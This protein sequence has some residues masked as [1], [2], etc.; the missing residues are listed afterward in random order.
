MLFWKFGWT[1]EIFVENLS[2][3]LQ[4][5]EIFIRWF[6]E[7]VDEFSNQYIFVDFVFQIN[8]VNE[9]NIFL[10][11]NESTNKYFQQK[12]FLDPINPVFYSNSAAVYLD[13]KKYSKAR[14]MC[15]KAID[16]SM[17]YGV[18]DKIFGKILARLGNLDQ[19]EGNY[20]S[21]L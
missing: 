10:N 3:F 13:L 9:I 7:F 1:I 11:E 6:V 15:L 19:Q 21:G 20:S 16:L 17:E 18:E 5:N 8:F 2:T 14:E 12:L 4:I